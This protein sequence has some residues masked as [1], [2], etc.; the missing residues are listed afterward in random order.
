MSSISGRMSSQFGGYVRQRSECETG[1]KVMLK[2]I[3]V[4]IFVQIN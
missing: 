4:F 1:P 3:V 2:I